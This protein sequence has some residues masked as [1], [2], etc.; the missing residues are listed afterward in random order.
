MSLRSK[1]FTFILL[2]R[3]LD[4][5]STQE[6][7]ITRKTIDFRGRNV[8]VSNLSVLSGQSLLSHELE[9]L[10]FPVHDRIRRVRRVVRKILSKGKKGLRWALIILAMWPWMALAV[11]YIAA[12]IIFEKLWD[13]STTNK[14]DDKHEGRGR[15]RDRDTDSGARDL[16]GSSDARNTGDS[17]ATIAVS[18]ENDHVG[19]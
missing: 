18:D 17:S 14:H 9:S 13:M 5:E 8:S 11:F 4:N 2:S 15:A 12:D 7:D 1:L 16:S 10:G 6:N 19:R 3:N